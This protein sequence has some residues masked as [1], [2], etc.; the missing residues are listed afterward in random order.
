MEATN[1][2]KFKNAIESGLAAARN[3][4]RALEEIKDVF[5]ALRKAML[6]M[7]DENVRIEG[8]VIQTDFLKRRHETRD[9]E[10]AANV[11]GRSDY[12]WK[13]GQISVTSTGYPVIVTDLEGV[14]RTSTSP[15]ELEDHLSLLLHTPEFGRWYQ[16]ISSFVQKRLAG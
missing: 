1:P 8:L 13:V 5:A 2:V 6:A 16:V 3:A 9:V 4:D 7:S 11:N 12:R 10:I 14:A 15:I